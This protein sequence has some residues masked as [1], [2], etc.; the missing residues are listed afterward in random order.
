[1]SQAK[2]CSQFCLNLPESIRTDTVPLLVK[3]LV[4]GPWRLALRPGRDDGRSSHCFDQLHY[5]LR[6]IAFVGQHSLGFPFPQ[7][8]NCLCAV[9][10]LFGRDYEVRQPAQLMVQ[11]VNLGS[12]TLSRKSC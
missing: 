1:M 11:Q 10:D 5:G 4:V 3:R 2:W 6:I 12:H 7:Q 9:S 8:R